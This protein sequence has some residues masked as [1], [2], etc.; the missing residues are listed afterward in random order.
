M[1]IYGKVNLPAAVQRG[2][3][4]YLPSQHPT[5]TSVCYANSTHLRL[6]IPGQTSY[7]G[8]ANPMRQWQLNAAVML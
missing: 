2:M 3:L 8:Q 4:I 5:Y 1:N 6:V 7:L